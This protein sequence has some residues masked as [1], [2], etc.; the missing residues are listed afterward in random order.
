MTTV[1][2]V[3]FA[4][5]VAADAINARSTGGQDGLDELAASI[6]AKGLIQPLCVRPSDADGAS[7]RSAE[8]FEIIDGRR[9]YQAIARLVKQKLLKKD[10]PVPVLV[11][12]ED[13]AEALETSLMANVVRLP[14]HPVD[15]HEVM[16]RLAESGLSAA[17]IAARFGIAERTAKQHLALGRLAPEVRKAWRDGTIDAETAQAFALAEDPALQAETLA[18]LIKGDRHGM[19][20]RTWEV[21]QALRQ[22]RIRLDQCDALQFVGEAAYLAAGGR[23]VDD[24]FEEAR[25]VADPGIARRLANEQMK[26]KCQELIADGWGWAEIE[27]DSKLDVYDCD[28]V[29]GRDVDVTGEGH[30]FTPE[31]KARSGCLVSLET[32]FDEVAKGYVTRIAVS[33]GL[34][35]P[36]DDGQADLED[37][38]ARA[39]SA[40]HGAGAVSAPEAP[41]DDDDPFEVPETLRITIHEAMTVASAEVLKAN[42][43]TALQV[44]VAQLECS[45]SGGPVKVSDQGNAVVSDRSKRDYKRPFSRRLRDVDG[46]LIEAMLVTLAGRV[47]QSL[48]MVPSGPGIYNATTEAGEVAALRDFLPGDHYLPAMRRHFPAAD[49]F[50]RASKATAIAALEDMHAGGHRFGLSGSEDLMRMK[51]A[52]LAEWAAEQAKACGWL[53]PQL[54]H[55]DYALVLPEAKEKPAARGKMAAARDTDAAPAKRRARA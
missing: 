49:Y 5:L 37:A 36:V 32:D 27:D 55:R 20:V 1:T 30:D 50:A 11:R 39:P 44:L 29:L 15:Q 12:N 43:Y 16:A 45:N 40:A 4:A 28:H 33:T 9:R 2:T 48:N 41:T 38:V 21:R 10:H 6:V 51:K 17:D 23:I 34:I 18:R 14:M 35:R 7:G 42:V 26:A 13:D 53:P 25:Y 54:R 52:A 47:A 22:D 31:Q 46:A 19:G 3:P 8:K 24:L